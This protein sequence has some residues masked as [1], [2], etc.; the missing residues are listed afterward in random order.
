[1][2]IFSKLCKLKIL[3]NGSHMYNWKPEQKQTDYYKCIVVDQLHNIILEWHIIHL[4][5]TDQDI[6]YM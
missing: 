4:K 3:F 2:V 1:M 5:S 6:E